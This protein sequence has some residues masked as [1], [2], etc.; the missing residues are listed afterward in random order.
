MARRFDGHIELL[1]RILMMLLWIVFGW[2]KMTSFGSTVALM[3]AF[4]LP[5]PTI[6]AAIAVVMELLVGLALILGVYVR[7]LAM[8]LALYTLATALI[9]H[10]FWNLSD[11][12]RLE[13]ME[14]FF[15]NI[16]IMGSLLLLYV[17]GAGRFTLD[18]GRKPQTGDA[19]LPPVS[20]S[21]SVRSR[22]QA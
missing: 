7:P 10:Q 18:A 9:G 5:F 13:D 1:A 4:G 19:G 21:G 15:K 16:S 8:A 6:S 14:T 12:A 2:M 11:K 20:G 22:R 3:Q 17:A